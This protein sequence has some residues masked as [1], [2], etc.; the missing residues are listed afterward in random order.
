MRLVLGW[1][2]RNAIALLALVFALGGTSYAV[3]NT[4]GTQTGN[5]TLCVGVRSGS[6]RVVGAHAKCRR[7]ERTVTVS[8]P[9]GV[10]NLINSVLPRARVAFA[11]N[12][13]Q[14]TSA[15]SATTALGA[16]PTGPAGGDLTGSYPAPT[17][18]A[19]PAPTNVAPNPKTTTDPCAGAD[20][21]V[22]VFCGT[23]SGHWAAG[24]YADKGL[25]FWRDRLGDVHIRGEVGYGNGVEFFESGG[26]LFYLPARDRPPQIESFPVLLGY[27]AGAWDSGAA[28]LVT[29]FPNGDVSL[30]TSGGGAY[31]GIFLGSIEFRTDA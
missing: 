1:L 24:T 25:Q 11:A 17:I 28:G 12:A 22:A 23:E 20:P 31:A 30:E 15:R 2:R 19:E 29:I 9:T 27:E 5:V 14:A 6:V 8:S 18:A 16:P 21:E 3:T 7:R 10:R 26:P 4:A 13:G